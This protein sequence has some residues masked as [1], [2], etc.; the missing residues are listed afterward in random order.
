MYAVG[1]EQKERIVSGKVYLV[2]AGPGSADL[3]TVRGLRLLQTADV[4]LHDALI[5]QDLID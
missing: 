5:S 4:L 1:I 2:G 3:I